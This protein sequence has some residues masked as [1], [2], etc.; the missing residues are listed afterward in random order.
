[1]RIKVIVLLGILAVV[2]AIFLFG[3][4]KQEVPKKNIPLPLCSCQVEIRD[5]DAKINR[6][7]RYID[8]IIKSCDPDAI[9]E[10]ADNMTYLDNDVIEGF[11]NER[12]RRLLCEKSEAARDGA[13]ERFSKYCAE[14]FGAWCEANGEDCDRV[15][16]RQ[17]R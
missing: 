11:K 6:L 5:R 4:P 14:C 8:R 13:I 2:M 17:W 1:M 3:R 7:E 10:R 16:V 15:R 9:G 12:S